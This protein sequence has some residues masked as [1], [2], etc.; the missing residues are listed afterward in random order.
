MS[1][2]ETPAAPEVAPSPAPSTALPLFFSSVVG[3]NPAQHAGLKLDRAAGFG[4]AAAAQAIPI[5]L[6]EFDVACQHYP[7][8]FTTGPQP[9]PM[10]LM[11]LQDGRN[12]FVQPNGAW[13]VDS[14]IPAYTRAYPFIFVE[15]AAKKTLFVGMEPNSKVLSTTQGV[16][17]F[18]DGKPSPALNEAISFCA[19]FRESLNAGIAFGAAMQEAG[20]LEEE[21]ANIN[22]ATGGTSRVRGF[23]VLKAERLAKVDDAT[24]LAWRHRGWI[25]AIYAHLH[26]TPRWAKLVEMTMPTAA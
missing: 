26:S 10:A 18:E 4:F 9:T 25:G 21:E 23:K 3:I 14:Y 7:I 19:A 8:V 15:D 22:F 12:L 24:Y 6:G 11:G 20:L 2:T 1:E 5:G 16:A 13:K 17:L